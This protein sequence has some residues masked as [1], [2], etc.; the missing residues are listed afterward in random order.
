M[1]RKE[2]PSCSQT[3][4]ATCLC[5]CQLF[6]YLRVIYASSQAGWHG[7]P[8]ELLKD[9]QTDHRRLKKDVVTAWEGMC[10]ALLNVLLFGLTPLVK[11]C[12]QGTLDCQHPSTGC[13]KY[14]V[15]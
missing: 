1:A 12:M 11:V 5:C 4:I 7:L 2:I 13:I 6:F 9:K 15:L 3:D 10:L 8:L 14:V